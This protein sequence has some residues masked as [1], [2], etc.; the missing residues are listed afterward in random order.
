MNK[1]TDLVSLRKTIEEDYA[2]KVNSFRLLPITGKDILVGDSIIAFMLMKKYGFESWINMGIAG[3]TTTG[4]M[5]RLDAVIR[6]KPKKVIVSVGSNDLVLT[7]HSLEEIAYHLRD[8]MII[9]KSHD[10]D[11]Y[12]LLVTPI[13]SSCEHANHLYIANRTNEMIYQLNQIIKHTL[14][15]TDII[16]TY[17]PLT[18]T[19]NEL[20]SRYSKDGIHLND[21]G[22]QIFTQTIHDAL[23]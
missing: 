20:D 13:C 22:Y 9:L 23:R 15:N 8:I 10:I 3:D 11:V 17:T 2:R 21:L 12:Y 16:D 4:V 14:L 18:N 7:N 19:H 6:Q 1:M 5:E